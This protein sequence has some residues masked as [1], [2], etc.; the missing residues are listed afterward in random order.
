[1]RNASA[2]P[3]SAQRWMIPL[4]FALLLLA[5]HGLAQQ[6]VID[7]DEGAPAYVETGSW[8]QGGSAG[9]SGGGYRF[10]YTGDN[11]ATWQKSVPSDGTYE[12]FAAYLR[13][14]NRST[15]VPHE[16]THAGGVD[17]VAID[18][19]G[20]LGMTETSL[21]VFPFSTSQ[22]ANIRLV[23][24]GGSN[25]YIAD[26]IILRKVS[27]DAPVITGLTVSPN[28][29]AEGKLITFSATISS[30][31]PLTSVQ[32]RYGI[33]A[34]TNT[35]TAIA[36]PN[37]TWSRP[38]PPQAQGSLIHYQFVATNEGG[39]TS[40][41]EVAIV[42][43]PDP[44]EFRV[45]WADSWGSSFLN[46]T[47]AQELVN[48][49]RAAN[50]NTLMPQVRKVGDAVYNNSIEPR[51]TNISGGS[52]FDP[53]QY[54]INLA[55]DTSGGKKRLQVHAWF[56]MHRIAQKSQSLHPQHPLSLHPEW[57]MYARST[58]QPPYEPVGGTQRYLD[59]GHPDAVDY[60][61]AVILHVMDNYDIDG[62]NLDYIR[63]PESADGKVHGYNPVSIARFNAVHGRSGIPADSDTLWRN[64]RRECVTLAVKK[65]YVQMWKRD[66]SVLLSTCT[67]N[68]GSNYSPS[69]YATSSAYNG[70]YQDWKGWL[71]AG[72][73][74]YNA[75]MNYVSQS[76]ST[77]PSRYQGWTDLSLAA[78]DKRGS[79]IGI[80][81]YLHTNPAYS[82]QQLLY[83]RNQGAAGLNIYD[84]GSEVQ[85]ASGFTRTQFFD[86]IRTEV[87][88]EWVDAPV[89][90]WKA[91]PVTG[92]IE[93]HVFDG[94]NP[95]DHAQ[96]EVVGQAQTATVTDGN[97]WF[98]I[99]HLPPGV[100]TLRVRIPGK[101]DIFYQAQN[102]S[103]GDVQTIT[104]GPAEV[105]DFFGIF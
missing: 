10:C 33:G 96:V 36:G 46:A 64:W 28:P 75:L 44:R 40:E 73:I 61:I 68:W 3:S 43:V 7:N 90:Q 45:I 87:F 57:E 81:A 41:S 58:T 13:S 65:L 69:N 1:M 9:Y 70:V 8:S 95:V 18:Q 19:N 67:I 60:N 29:P 47:Q 89:P 100:H 24:T 59:P 14:S 27:V 22:P 86:T 20:A 88:Q 98:G 103:A 79:I 94:P 26:A 83:A 31:T 55:H 38:I 53:L 21:G 32:V 63:Y 42:R 80:G 91:N 66:P 62:V 4:V 102:L 5:A 50:I 56:V 97:G 77:V 99:L 52:S 30:E 49:A 16:I 105:R 39:F 82:A 35:L 25:V 78:D 12:V 17:T 51:A 92:I 76:T 85:A 48:T 104:I 74:D 37:S 54:L 23:A 34:L 101:P 15:Y 84:W 72:I 71:E 6:I 93:G 11:T 2:M